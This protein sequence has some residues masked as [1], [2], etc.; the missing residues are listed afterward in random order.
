MNSFELC[1]AWREQPAPYAGPSSQVTRPKNDHPRPERS[2]GWLKDKS[3]AYVYIY[4]A[5]HESYTVVPCDSSY[6]H[7]VIQL[8]Y[9]RVL[10]C[11]TE[12]FISFELEKMVMGT[13]S[14][15]L[16]GSLGSSL[17]VR[18]RKRH[19]PH[20]WSIH[21]SPRLSQRF[22]HWKKKEF[23]SRHRPL[24]VRLCDDPWR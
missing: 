10:C 12:F 23:R 24:A 19:G 7:A 9:V 21:R 17:R 4:I 18:A 20:L 15:P 14:G 5:K 3:I 16:S 22:G 1:A 6:I 11:K 2:E 8:D 13:S